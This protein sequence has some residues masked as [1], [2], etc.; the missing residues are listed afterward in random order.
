M[1]HPRLPLLLK[2]SC[3]TKTC[4]PT[5]RECSSS[6]SNIPDVLATSLSPFEDSTNSTGSM[7]ETTLPLLLYTHNDY[8]AMKVSWWCQENEPHSYS[9]LFTTSTLSKLQELLRNHSI[10]GCRMKEHVV[11]THP[12]V[13]RT[14][15]WRVLA[16]ICS[17]CCCS[18]LCTEWIIHFQE[19]SS[20]RS[21]HGVYSWWRVLHGL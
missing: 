15:L 19:T 2:Q 10:A 21:R 11:C 8:D 4:F 5:R 13:E 1:F 7:N 6:G 17:C 16:E 3:V 20:A 18:S 12:S 9:V 14:Y